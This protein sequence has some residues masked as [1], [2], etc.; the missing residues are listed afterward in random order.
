MI[1]CPL[2]KFKNED[3]NEL[4]KD[5]KGLFSKMKMKLI[6]RTQKIQY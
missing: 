5:K 1:L 6:K 2:L 3:R 4:K